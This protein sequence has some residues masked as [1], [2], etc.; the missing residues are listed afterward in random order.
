MAAIQTYFPKDSFDC[1]FEEKT[2]SPLI[3]SPNIAS[4][5]SKFNF[6][7]WA[8]E[9]QQA[10]A[11]AIKEFGAI[12]FSG[13]NLDFHAAFSALTGGAP[14]AYKGDTPRDEVSYQI[15]HSTAVANAHSIPLHQEVSGGRRSDMPK[16]IAFFC[17][18][19]PEQGTG[20]TLV[21]N[22]SQVS[23]KIQS[24]MPDLWSCMTSKTLTYTARYLPKNSWRTNWI[25][26]FNPSHAT[27]EKRFGTENRKEV[28]DK[29]KEEGL[30]CEWDGDWAVISRKGVPA[31]IDYNG[32]TLFCNQIHLDRLSPKLC[33]GWI[34]YIFARILLYPT[35]RSMQFDVQFDDE[36]Q[37]SRRDVSTLLTILQEHQEGRDWKKGDLMLL[38][39]ISTMHAKASHIGKR[40]ILVAMGDPSKTVNN[41]LA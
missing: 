33:G 41:P 38:D 26:W 31:T 2:K 11:K 35:K 32:E 13:F 23:K 28:E 6:L 8:R 15:Y 40:E 20:Q 16:Y 21:G 37:I 9:N 27:I 36:T 12:V 24:L 39:N 22:V 10:V 1:Y 4:A 30:T 3:V 5:N 18:T 34:N 19:P 17:V 14:Q 29:C 7:T 25:R